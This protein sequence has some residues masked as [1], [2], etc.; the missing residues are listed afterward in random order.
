MRLMKIVCIDYINS[1]FLNNLLFEKNL[2]SRIG[3]YFIYKLHVFS[4]LVVAAVENH[5][6]GEFLLCSKVLFVLFQIARPQ[7]SK[8]DGPY[9]DLQR[10]IRSEQFLIAD[11]WMR[12]YT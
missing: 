6:V 10:F 1:G 7:G 4:I 2:T 9:P 12:L 8:N 5:Q 3:Y 11:L